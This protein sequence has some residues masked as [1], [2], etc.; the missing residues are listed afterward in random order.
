MS[1]KPVPGGVYEHE[2]PR[3][4]TDPGAWPDSPPH[5][6]LPWAFGPECR[7]KKALPVSFTIPVEQPVQKEIG[8]YDLPKVERP[9]E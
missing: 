6:F 1:D 5:A 7:P 4:K 3:A 9:K 2:K 8:P